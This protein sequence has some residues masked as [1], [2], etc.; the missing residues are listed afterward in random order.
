[1]LNR[2]PLIL[3]PALV[4]ELCLI[5]V[6]TQETTIPT[7]PDDFCE[8]NKIFYPCK[9][10]PKV[11]GNLETMC[12]KNC[13][14]ECYCKPG[15]VLAYKD[16]TTCIPESDCNSCGPHGKF[17]D[18]NSSCQDTCDNYRQANKPCAMMCTPGCICDKGYVMSN[19]KCI[20]PEQCPK[21]SRSFKSLLLP[22]LAPKVNLE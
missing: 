13:E 20:S 12:M 8:H 19:G 14:P 16:S 11:C 1:M 10:C 2:I 6:T 15:Y 5:A 18:C 7:K 4:L 21:K 17:D 9:P 3:L 22:L